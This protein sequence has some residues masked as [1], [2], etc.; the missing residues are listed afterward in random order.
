MFYPLC[1]QDPF[2]D[3]SDVF[4]HDLEEEQ[5]RALDDYWM[6]NDLESLLET[7]LE[8]IICHVQYLPKD[9]GEEEMGYINKANAD[10]RKL[11]SQ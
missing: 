2:P 9:S 5:K 4:K 6:K 11:M 10:Y 1:T 7:L 8:F 3:L